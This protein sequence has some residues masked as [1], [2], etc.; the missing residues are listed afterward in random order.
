MLKVTADRIVTN[1]TTK[2]T[3][4]SKSQRSP[5]ESKFRR[6]KKT[7]SYLTFQLL[8]HHHNGRIKDL[9]LLSACSEYVYSLPS[10]SSIQDFAGPLEVTELESFGTSWNI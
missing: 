5:N 7:T 8:N 2:A 6:G 9:A 4:K 3:I 1:C 10:R